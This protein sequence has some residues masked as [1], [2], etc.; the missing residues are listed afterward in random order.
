MSDSRDGGGG[1]GVGGGGCSRKY[2]FV[3]ILSIGSD[4]TL[5]ETHPNDVVS[6]HECHP[7]F[8]LMFSKDGKCF[9]LTPCI[10]DIKSGKR[11][12]GEGWA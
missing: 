8:L 5:P 4:I 6:M 2:L 1:V 12:V 7:Y 11:G 9:L 3:H 10:N